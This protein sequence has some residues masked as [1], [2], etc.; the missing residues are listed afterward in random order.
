MN[1]TYTL[2]NSLIAPFIQFEYEDNHNNFS[3]VSA[4]YSN[5]NTLFTY[6]ISD[7]QSFNRLIS[8]LG[9]DYLN[10]NSTNINLNYKYAKDVESNIDASSHSVNFK[11]NK[12]F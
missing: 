2:S 5:S 12:N 9:F 4:T 11:L 6:D 8:T 1:Q 3:D 10:T 7:N